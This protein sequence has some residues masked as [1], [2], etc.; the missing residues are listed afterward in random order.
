MGAAPTLGHYSSER[1]F[2]C[3]RT[4]DHEEPTPIFLRLR[5]Y[6]SHPNLSQYLRGTCR[7]CLCREPFE[8]CNGVYIEG[9]T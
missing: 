5:F 1:L 9:N 6:P 4:I 8:V 2:S 7:S 3:P